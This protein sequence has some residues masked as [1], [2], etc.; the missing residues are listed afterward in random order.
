MRNTRAHAARSASPASLIDVWDTRAACYKLPAFDPILSSWNTYFMERLSRMEDAQLL[1]NFS[2]SPLHESG[3][4]CDGEG[5]LRARTVRARA[6]ARSHTRA[7]TYTRICAQPRAGWTPSRIERATPH[8]H[9]HLPPQNTDMRAMA[10]FLVAA[11]EPESAERAAAE[12]EAR[13]AWCYGSSAA[14]GGGALA[15]AAAECGAAEGGAA[16]EDGWELVGGRWERVAAPGAGAAGGG[17]A[18]AVAAAG[19]A[20]AAGAEAARLPAVA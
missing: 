5:R 6:P 8:T 14:G 3:W 16:S 11:Q 1:A 12:A 19:E 4:F 18:A 13:Y 20:A 15:V 7:S 9:A 10:G 17:A 2:T